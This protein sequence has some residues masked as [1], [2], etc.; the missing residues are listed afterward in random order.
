MCFFVNNYL[1]RIFL[2]I[3][4]TTFFSKMLFATE[5]TD[6]QRLQFV[7]EE[8]KEK[9][10]NGIKMAESDLAQ[11]IT[12]LLDTCMKEVGG[13][14]DVKSQD[15]LSILDFLSPKIGVYS[16]PY[17][18]YCL[19]RFMAGNAF[20][21]SP[22]EK[23]RDTL[24][25]LL[26]MATDEQYEMFHRSIV[27]SIVM[28]CI[29]S[30][31]YCRPVADQI[32]N[33]V[34]NMLLNKHKSLQRFQCML[35][36]TRIDKSRITPTVISLLKQEAKKCDRFII[37]ESKSISFAATV[38]LASMGDKDN[39]RKFLNFMHDNGKFIDIESAKFLFPYMTLVKRREVVLLLKE[40][41]QSE[42]EVDNG[43]DIMYR[44]VGYSSLAAAS[45][46]VMLECFP[47][48]PEERCT[49]EYR[50]RCLEFLSSEAMVSFKKDIDWRSSNYIISRIRYMIF[51]L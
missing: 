30:E 31:L 21:S 13:S 6:V 42:Q 4:I 35:L 41:L 37:H 10:D 14:I 2:A 17:F 45:L 18:D 39:L 23:R 15:G 12:P 16:N 3:V 29:D 50:D 26:K 48:P 9:L 38:V 47:E 32:N 8:I 24:S 46:Y 20:Q 22:I 19:W 28:Y 33:L 25:K 43:E 34:K 40:Y 5:I 27:N 1:N 7:I 11:R 36:L 44:Y 51:G 49:K